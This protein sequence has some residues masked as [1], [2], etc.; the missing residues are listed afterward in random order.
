MVNR[1]HFFVDLEDQ[2]EENVLEYEHEHH[3]HNDQEQN[4]RV[5]VSLNQLRH[6]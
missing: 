6:H 4:G 2:V 3:N 5:L 1:L